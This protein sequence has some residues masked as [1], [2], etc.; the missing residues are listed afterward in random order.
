MA[1]S[2]IIGIV[3]NIQRFSIQDGPGIRTTVFLKGCPLECLWCSNC[4]SQ[5]S[6]PEL[7]HRDLLCTGCG[8][9]LK[10]CVEEAIRLSEG[11]IKIDR[12]RCTN[13]GDCIDVCQI[14]ALRIFGQHMTVDE[15]LSEVKKDGLC[16]LNSDGGVLQ[17]E[18]P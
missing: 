4:E 14:G 13:C 8:D 11:A 15:V 17:E 9:C 18:S 10:V 12:K 1:S 6:F 7:A 3:F 5:Y 2:A 16:Y